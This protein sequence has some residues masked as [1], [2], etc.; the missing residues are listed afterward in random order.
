M[1]MW[2]GVRTAAAAAAA[3]ALFAGTAAA[4]DVQYGLK[5]GLNVSNIGF[6]AED[7]TVLPGAR[8]G[9][10]VGG[11]AERALRDGWSGVAEVLLTMKGSKL[12]VPGT[13]PK[14]RLTYLEVPV[15][16]RAELLG[17]RSSRVHLYAGPAFAFKVGENVDP[18][19]DDDDDTSGDDVFQPFDFSL[20]F[21]GSVLIREIS[22][23]VRYTMGLV[24][25]ADEDDF[26]IGLTARN[27]TF[28]VMIGWR[29]Y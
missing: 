8:A 27:R 3:I 20:A 6:T 23:D 7:V 19:L 12:D 26:D 10:V 29:L 22:V 17:P 25:V 21:G 24:N 28:S 1:R 15:L 11:Y 2:F 5:A 14:V 4:Q 13:D 9:L 16:A 18:D